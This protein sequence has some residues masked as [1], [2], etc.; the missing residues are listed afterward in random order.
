[1]A[2]PK[3]RTGRAVTHARRSANDTCQKQGRSICPRC[4]EVKRPHCICP[5]CG[6]YKGKEILEVE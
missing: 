4:G 5:S 6:F 1:M 2:V 3:R